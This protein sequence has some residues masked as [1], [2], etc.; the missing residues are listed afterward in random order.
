MRKVDDLFNQIGD[1][2]CLVDGDEV[3]IDGVLRR[4]TDIVVFRAKVEQ[5]HYKKIDILH[6]ELQIWGTVN[7]TSVTLMSAFCRRKG[8]LSEVNTVDV[9]FTPTQIIVG[10]CYKGEPK[11][12]A[13]SAS[14]TALNRMF[15]SNPLEVIY[16]FSKEKPYLLKFTY[17]DTVETDDK[18]GHLEIFQ[19]I[20]QSWTRNEVTHK[21]VPIIK[22]QFTNPIGVMDAVEGVAVV[23]NLFSFFS[24]GYL[25]LENITFA[26][27]QTQKIDTR[28]QFDITLY[29]NYPEEIAVHNEPFLIMTSDFATNFSQIWQNWLEM[30]Q[31]AVPIPTLFYEIICNRSTRANRFLNLAQAIEVYSDKFRKD[32]AKS[33][34]KIYDEQSPSRKKGDL[35]LKIK[36]EDVLSFLNDCLEVPES[37]IPSMAQ[38][39]ADMRN[40]YTHYN[41]GKYVEPEFREMNCASHVL[42][43]VLLS[44]VY[45]T[46]GLSAEAIIDVRKRVYSKLFSHDI[47]TV[48]NYASKKP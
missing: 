8:F 26:D 19:T 28:P 3:H 1:F 47:E 6:D 11:A 10:R 31:G 22:Y 48:V 45:K 23:R 21:L 16:D 2:Y 40:Y 7:G 30:Y 37:N 43:F 44:I 18:L 12:N 17:P 9:E 27:D 38:G 20:S 46:I 4:E 34:A 41:I 35:T 32:E 13:I 33:L 36:V 15:S 25:P 5:E 24:N 42:R 39:I 14:I 29:L